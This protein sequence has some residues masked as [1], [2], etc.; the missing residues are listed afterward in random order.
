MNRNI[1]SILSDIDKTE[2]KRYLKR[3]RELY[4]NEETPIRILRSV[5]N[6]R[7]AINQYLTND[8]VEG[9]DLDT[10]FFENKKG[11]FRKRWYYFD[12][13]FQ[14]WKSTII[15]EDEYTTINK[16]T[17]FEESRNIGNPQWCFCYKNDKW[18]QHNQE[19]KETIYFIHC[20]IQPEIWQYNAVCVLPNNGMKI[21]DSN[22]R[23]LSRNGEIDGYLYTL[24]EKAVSVIN[25]D[26]S[27]INESKNYKNMKKNVQRINESQLRAIVAESVKRVLKEEIGDGTFP[28]LDALK[29]HNISRVEQA[30]E[31]AG[32]E[33]D[34]YGDT[35]HGDG[36]VIFRNPE[37]DEYISVSYPWK[38]TGK[39]SYHAGKTT[40]ASRWT[41]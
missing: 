1:E 15:Y 3:I 24:G 32:W 26:K 25:S 2:D 34:E 10:L 30:L 31:S 39:D 20:V 29:G 22:H 37:T 19:F 27:I 23:Y 5:F 12:E 4:Y 35:L 6:E 17:S 41:Y 28:N 40:D 18:L 33:I 38:R 9:K 21:L 36:E 11:T 14:S 13:A 16:P 7:C 8:D